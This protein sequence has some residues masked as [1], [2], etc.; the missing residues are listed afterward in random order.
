MTSRG[1]AAALVAAVLAT[2]PAPPRTLAESA[3]GGDHVGVTAS[4]DG[5]RLDFDCAHGTI[6]GPIALDADG[7]FDVRGTYTK[8]SPGPVRPGA[9]GG[10]A[11]RYVGRI[12][13]DAMT[14][15]VVLVGSDEK[16][17]S[18]TLQKDRLPRVHKCQ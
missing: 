2:T 3:W 8:E 15:A 4:R 13:G 18:F 14:L 16:V 1:P 9:S 17:G 10:E 11:A 5:M 6:D 7:R 12:D